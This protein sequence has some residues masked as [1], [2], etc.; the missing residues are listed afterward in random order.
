LAAITHCLPAPSAESKRFAKAICGDDNDPA[1]FAQALIIAENEMVLRA[2]RAQRVAVVERLREKTAIALAKGN[3]SL[4][5]AKA[6]F[7]ES[8][9]AL[10]ELN[11]LLPI[12]IEKY[13]DRLPADVCERPRCELV[14][15]EVQ[16]LLRDRTQTSDSIE[17]PPS[18]TL[19]IDRDCGQ[20]EERDEFEAMEMG[21]PDLIRLDRYERRIWSRQKRAIRHFLK[22]KLAPAPTDPPAE[23]PQQ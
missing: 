7:K 20:V 4:R 9:R 2:I 3:N 17:E 14:P 6:R 12:V 16:L 15:L 21:A 8:K 22:M 23:P 11:A 13:K 19:P 5:L 18:A 10:A 1:V